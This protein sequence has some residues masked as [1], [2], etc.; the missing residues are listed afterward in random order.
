MERHVTLKELR[1]KL[2]R[3]VQRV[4]REMDRYFVSKRGKPLAVILGMDDY[5]SL[6]ETLNETSDKE[7]LER[8]K[9]AL[10]EATKGRTAS[11]SSVKARLGL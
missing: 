1:P 8:I 11:W 10:R 6:V 4:D 7:G 2:P 3:I 9:K 5:E